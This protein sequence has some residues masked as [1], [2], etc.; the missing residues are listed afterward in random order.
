MTNK[1]YYTVGP[2]DKLYRHYK[3]KKLYIPFIKA[4]TYNKYYKSRQFQET[5]RRATNAY[6]LR[7]KNER[8]QMINLSGKTKDITI[9]GRGTY[10][11]PIEIFNKIQQACKAAGVDVR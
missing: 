2:G 7:C 11:M 6:I 8:K 3:G 5:L 4:S 10:K 9:K 1:L